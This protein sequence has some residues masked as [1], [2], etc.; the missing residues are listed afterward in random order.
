VLSSITK[1]G[2][3]KVHLA[4]VSGLVSMTY[5]IKELMS[6]LSKKRC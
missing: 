3:L 6:L 4:P 2:I 5:K 1:R